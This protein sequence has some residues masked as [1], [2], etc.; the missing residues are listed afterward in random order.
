MK[1]RYTISCILVAC[2]TALSQPVLAD[3][4]KKEIMQ[5]HVTP[6]NMNAMFERGLLQGKVEASFLFN[7]NLNAFDI[8]T[9]IQK[10]KAILSGHVSNELEKDLATHVALNVEGINEVE[11][12]I[13]VD[14]EK[15]LAKNLKEVKAAVSE[16]A[17]EARII[18][19]IE[20][21][22]AVNGHLSALG[23]DVNANGNRVILSGTVTSAL[24]RDMAELIAKNTEGVAAVDNQLRIDP[25]A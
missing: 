10:D 23:I 14:E 21:K 5:P 2:I 18:T 11:N 24:H 25:D 7:E 9:S 15:S 12:N 16:V 4:A 22:Y 3:D 20:S 6:D 19:T 8:S 1:L 17:N 13:I